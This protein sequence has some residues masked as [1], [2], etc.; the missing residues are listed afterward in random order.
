MEPKENTMANQQI[1]KQKFS[2]LFLQVAFTF[3]SVLI[4]YAGITIYISVSS[5]GKYSTE[6]NQKL[7]RELASNMLGV[8]SPMVETD[9]INQQALSD[10]MHSMMV[11]NPSV[12]V[13]ILSP[14]GK[15]LSYVA[16]YKVVKLEE[17]NL[18]PIIN[19]IEGEGND[20][21]YGD[22]PRNPEE[23]KIFSA[24]EIK[25]DN[26]L[27]GYLYIVLASQAYASTSQM[28]IG[29][30]ILGL[31]IRSL[32]AILFITAVMG[33]IAFYFLTKNLNAISQAM[34]QFKSGKYETR[35]ESI[36]QS[37]FG[38]IGSTFNNMAET[39]QK[40][41]EE[42]KSVDKLRKELISNVSHDLRSPVASIQGYAE[43]LVM[44]K[45]TATP[46]EKEEYLQAIV[47]GSRRLKN[48]VTELFEL[49]KLET[50]QVKPNFEP[51]VIGEL[52]HDIANKYKIISQKKGVSINTIISK[53]IPL[54]MAD[55][56]LLDRVLQNLIDNAIK[57]C[58]EGDTINIEV[59]TS[60]L[61]KVSVRV[62]DSGQGIKPEDLPNIFDRYY[63]GSGQKDG[64]G[65]GLAI[66]KKIVE[67]HQSEIIVDSQY[68]KGTQFMFTVPVAEAS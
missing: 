35:I 19:F 44:K 8:I 34:E 32:I 41:I 67:L 58:N 25:H 18:K 39:I 45:D 27:V 60:N 62:S 20:I 57:F 22:D 21:I 15:I 6:V 29:S 43:T 47:N 13:Y 5:A 66:V 33:L 40:N 11:I 51:L 55:I 38:R 59:N 2:K 63:K 53:D 10:I 56:S 52:I 16:P 31:S 42:I 14:K 12:E 50:N 37:E 17:V 49:S 28:V 36:S 7:N 26:D 30:Y 64:T 65:L 54:V 68:G 4:I 61:N 9:S 3:L 48:L 23:E 1:K 46:K 24:A